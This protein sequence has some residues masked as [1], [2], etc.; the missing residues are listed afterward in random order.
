LLSLGKDHLDWIIIESSVFRWNDRVQD[1]RR[2]Q[3]NGR[4]TQ[5]EFFLLQTGTVSE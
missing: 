3:E 5:A 1:K 4:L 2:Y